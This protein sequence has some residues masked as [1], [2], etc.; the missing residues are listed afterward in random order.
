MEVGWIFR[1]RTIKRMAYLIVRS[2]F[3]L[4][5]LRKLAHHSE[6]YTA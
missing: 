1:G 2:E 4:A 3:V 6:I 5:V